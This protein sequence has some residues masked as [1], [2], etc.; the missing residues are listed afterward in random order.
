MKLLIYSWLYEY[1]LKDI[2]FSLSNQNNIYTID[3]VSAVNHRAY[4][5]CEE[6]NEDISALADKYASVIG[7]TDEVIYKFKKA[8]TIDEFTEV[9]TEAMWWFVNNN[10][11][12]FDNQTVYFASHNTGGIRS[13]VKKGDFT[14]RDLYKV[15]P[16][17]NQLCIQ[18]CTETNINNMKSSTYYRTYSAPE[19][20]YDKYERTKA[21]SIS[22]ICEYKYAYNYQVSFKEYDL[23]A[24]DAL[25]S[26]LINNAYEE[27]VN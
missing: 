18:T 14:R 25:L 15:F 11:S 21:V 27:V 1:T 9:V 26:F 19:I 22:Y 2:L 17:D 7:K 20:I 8:Y 3:S 16:F 5:W 23:T 4:D 6:E 10:L 24:K 12:L 13:S